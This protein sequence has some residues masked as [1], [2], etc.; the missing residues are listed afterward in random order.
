MDRRLTTLL[1]LL[2][3]VG[4][5]KPTPRS[6]LPE[7]KALSGAV[8]DGDPQTYELLC[9]TAH[10]DPCDIGLEWD[11]ALSVGELVID[12]A[13]LA[14]RAYEPSPAGHRLE[15][16]TGSEWLTI[17]ASVEIDYRNHA[18]FALLE[19]SG[20]ARWTYRFAPV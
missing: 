11:A 17:P 19:G 14:G 3:S 8:V 2:A 4:S 5:G 10:N 9:T 15:R 1:F 16:W 7:P 20:T 18:E 12:V 6:W 13:T